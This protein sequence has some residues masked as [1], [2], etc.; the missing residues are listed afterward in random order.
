MTVE[1]FVRI[2][3]TVFEKFE[4]FIERSREKKQKKHNCISSRKFLR[5]L[6]TVFA[7]PDYMLNQLFY[8]FLLNSVT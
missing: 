8:N 7:N 4:I 3:W 5:L 2:V 1:N 6:K